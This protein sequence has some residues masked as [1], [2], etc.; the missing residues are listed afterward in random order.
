MI[1]V[2]M[3]FNGISEGEVE[4]LKEFVITIEEFENGIDDDSVSC[5]GSIICKD[6]SIGTG[7]TVKK[8]SEEH[9][10]VMMRLEGV[11]EEEEGY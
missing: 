10:R 7:I 3:S 11:S 9:R 6:V 5:R 4:F 8:L 2:N 1:S